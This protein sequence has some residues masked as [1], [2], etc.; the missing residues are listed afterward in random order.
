MNKTIEIIHNPRCGK[1]RDALKIAEENGFNV[2]LIEYLK[3]PLSE[4]EIKALLKQLGLKAQ[5]VIRKKEKV[6][7][8]NFSQQTFT[9]KEWIQIIAANPI[10]LERPIAIRNGK[11]LIC[12]PAE[13][14][15]TLL[16]EKV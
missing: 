7:I 8:D 14:I 15:L 4:K 10:L 2:Q 5:D 16:F 6:F 13:K 1:S 9:E 12:R 3:A 11:A